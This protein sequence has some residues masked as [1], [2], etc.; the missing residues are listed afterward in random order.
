MQ[1]DKVYLFIPSAQASPISLAQLSALLRK[2]L[3]KHRHESTTDMI[4]KQ[5]LCCELWSEDIIRS[6]IMANI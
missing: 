3:S 2:D 4:N 1:T 6:L 5:I